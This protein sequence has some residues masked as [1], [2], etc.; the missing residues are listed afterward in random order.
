M[1]GKLLEFPFEVHNLSPEYTDTIEARLYFLLNQVRSHPACNYDE[2]IIAIE[3]K[4]LESLLLYQE[5][6][7]EA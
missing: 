2:L 4:L 5:Y 3:L 6:L 1:N 7:S